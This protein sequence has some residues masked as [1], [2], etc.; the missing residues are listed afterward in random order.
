MIS[1]CSVPITVALVIIIVALWYAFSQK[2][3]ISKET[4]SKETISEETISEETISEETISEETI[5]EETISEETISEETTQEQILNAILGETSRVYEILKLHFETLDEVRKV[6][7]ILFDVR[8]M[9]I[10]TLN[11]AQAKT[12][13]EL[14]KTRKTLAIVLNK[15]HLVRHTLTNASFET[16][17]DVRYK[18]REVRQTLIKILATTH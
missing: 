13:Q 10:Q 1:F 16:I 8:F 14:N 4:I 11:K 2:E 7:G 17:D 5:S 18:I 15:I 9:I 12:N 3:T 6:Y